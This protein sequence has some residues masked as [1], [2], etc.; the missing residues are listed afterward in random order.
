[1]TCFVDLKMVKNKVYKFYFL[2]FL[3]HTCWHFLAKVYTLLKRERPS[4]QSDEGQQQGPS[5]L[6]WI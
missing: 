4:G 5:L 3:F 2:L 6:L 1:M